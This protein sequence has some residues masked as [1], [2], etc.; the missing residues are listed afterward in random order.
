[1][2]MAIV[3]LRLVPATV[4]LAVPRGATFRWRF[5]RSITIRDSST[6]PPTVTVVDL[7]LAS[8]ELYV[9][10]ALGARVLTLSS[11]DGIEIDEDGH[12]FIALDPEATRAIAPGKHRHTLWW[13][14]EDTDRVPMLHGIWDSYSLQDGP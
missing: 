8:F 13:V 7:S 14:Q 2:P 12:A 4:N 3:N 5:A 11:G 6:T 10:N 1:M 9:D